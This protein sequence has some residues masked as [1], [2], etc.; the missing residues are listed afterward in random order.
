MT[1]Q[2][3]RLCG[4]LKVLTENVKYIH[5]NVSGINFFETHKNLDEYYE[6]LSD[7]TD[8][9]I[10]VF[11]AFDDFKEPIF[12]ENYYQLERAT[13]YSTSR[14]YAIVQ[15]YFNI[16]IEEMEKVKSEVPSYIISKIE[17]YQYDLFKIANYMIKQRLKG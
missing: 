6:L 17:E 4:M 1:N 7:I 11:L 14:A 2:K 13:E 5:K 16:L 3:E 15:K 9:L 12:S 8:E 10:E